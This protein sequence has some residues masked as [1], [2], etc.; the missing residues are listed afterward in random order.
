[1][2][3]N[4]N[5]ERKYREYRKKERRTEKESKQW[6]FIKEFGVKVGESEME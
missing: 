3:S 5:G 4:T 6:K 2:S 1:M